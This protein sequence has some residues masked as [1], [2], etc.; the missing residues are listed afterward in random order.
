M[1]LKKLT[2]LG[3]LLVQIANFASADST[4]DYV[5]VITLPINIPAIG[6]VTAQIQD[7]QRNIDAVKRVLENES[8]I[9]LVSAQPA[10]PTE[11]LPRV[12]TYA[13]VFKAR[14]GWGYL[15]ITSIAS[16]KTEV[17][18]Y[19][20]QNGLLHALVQLPSEQNQEDER[21][22]NDDY[23]D[24]NYAGKTDTSSTSKEKQSPR[25]KINKL[26][27][28]AEEKQEILGQLDLLDRT[29][30]DAAEYS[31]IK[32]YID[33]VLA[34][35][36]NIETKDNLDIKH[37]KQIL[38]RDHHG[39]EKIKSDILDFISVRKLN[40]KGNGKI[41]CLVGPPGTGKTSICKSIA[42][43]LGRKYER[44]AL[45]GLKDEAEIRGHRRTY[46]G[47]LPG[48]I[49]QAIKKAQSNNPVM[50][51]DE[52][53][54]VGG[55][56]HGDPTAALLELLD[57]EQNNAFYD[58]YLAVPFDVSK[59]MFIATANSLDTIP[60]PL[61]DRMEVIEL[62][63]YTV[64]EKVHIAQQHVISKALKATG[65]QPEDISIT[66]QALEQIITEYTR[67]AGIR[68]L[69]R[70]IK[71]LCAKAARE[72]VENNKKIIFT[73]EN[74]R[75]YLDAPR[76]PFDHDDHKHR[77]GVAHG[78][79]WTPVGGDTLDIEAVLV[80]GQGKIILTGKLGEVMQESAQAALSYAKAH[81][82]QFAID[83]ALF[84][85]KDIHIHAPAGAI[86][87]DGPS[88]G[89]TILTAV[90]SAFTD[91]PVNGNYAMTGE[92]NLHGDVMPIGG[93]KEKILAAKQKLYKNIIVPIGN[94]NAVESLN[95]EVLKG[96]NIIYAKHADDVLRHV[97]NVTDEK[98]SGRF[99]PFGN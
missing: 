16:G 76:Y 78:L 97:F 38:D 63:G 1:S 21:Y 95:A 30:P 96:V 11:R 73:P 40:S 32:R 86:P 75:T 41:L 88:A 6:I 20:S 46:V 83:P 23:E 29:R 43:S 39:L 58:N 47:A 49:I 90:V 12:G 5:L 85:D 67:E 19:K 71:K 27:L 74:L 7:S 37:A 62:T 45:G 48:R 31:M 33:L 84:K 10:T 34:L 64:D 89:I 25:Q 24:N 82:K 65:L 8:R 35:P 68:Q 14:Y 98:S 54:K 18:E 56:Y 15:E 99:W 92:I 22:S 80:P 87:K 69:E 81:A 55:N 28:S 17:I 52:I 79:A 42:E 59:V 77:I 61:L 9:L 94:K 57:P 91:K 60:G 50:V 13:K 93:V 66:P 4:Q 3:M 72:K 51:L 53:D 26:P 70:V 36:W 44:V 2:L